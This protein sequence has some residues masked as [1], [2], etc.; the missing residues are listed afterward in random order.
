MFINC[1]FLVEFNPC[2]V[3]YTICL[4]KNYLWKEGFLW[5]IPQFL[6]F[7][8]SLIYHTTPNM[9]LKTQVNTFHGVRKIPE[10]LDIF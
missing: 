8:W 1:W 9:L 4:L 3:N 10:H 2:F 6:C 7:Q 5:C